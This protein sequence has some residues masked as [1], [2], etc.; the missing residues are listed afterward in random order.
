MLPSGS[1]RQ[2]YDHLCA[3]P[4]C[5][6]TTAPKLQVDAAF[7]ALAEQCA[8]GDFDSFLQALLVKLEQAEPGNSFY[9]ELGWGVAEPLAFEAVRLPPQEDARRCFLLRDARALEAMVASWARAEALIELSYEGFT[10]FDATARILYESEANRRITGYTREECL[11]KSL[12]DF[13]HPEDAE[14]LIPRFARLA[15]RPGE[16]DGDIVRWRHREGHWIY[17]E[18]TVVNQLGDPHIG[19]MINTF[20]D[21]TSRVE[22]ERVLSEAKEAAETA[23]AKQREF[24]AMLSHE[25]RTPLALVKQPLET[26]LPAEGADPQ[27]EFVKRGLRRMEALVDELVDFTILDAGQAQLRVRQVPVARILAEWVEELRP[28]AESRAMSIVLKSG[29]PGLDVFLDLA[30]FSKVVFNLLGNALKFAPAGSTVVVGYREVGGEDAGAPR[31]LEIEV[32]DAGVAIPEAAR[33]RI[34]ERFFQVDSGDT[35]GWEGMG[36]GLCLAA[37]M[38]ALHG[39]EIG[40]RPD[41]LRGNCFWVSVPLGADHIAPE[42]IALGGE[43]AAMPPPPL[44]VEA[45]SSTPAELISVAPDNGSPQTRLL[46][47]ED[48]PDLMR[49][50]ALHLESIYELEFA[51]NGLDALSLIETRRPDLIVS[52][53]M[54]PGL[55]GVSLCRQV[56]EAHSAEALPIILLSAKGSMDDRV[57][58]LEAGA[59]DY[60]GKPFVMSELINRLQLLAGRGLRAETELC[61][62]GITRLRQVIEERLAEADFSIEFLARQC[63]L[64][65][66]QLQR[67]TREELGQSPGG[68]VNQIRVAKAKTLLREAKHLTVA[69]IAAAVGLTPHYFS[70]LFRGM[71]GQTPLGFRARG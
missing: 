7:R 50:L 24:L 52:D 67:L 2:Q 4:W 38:V 20:H 68:W 54:M 58:G 61:H 1:K 62:A 33:E 8:P 27:W 21:V 47:V 65:I 35:R 64:S 11:G 66:R 56:R 5:L 39:G 40:L 12:F 41:R 13:I 51:V 30:K 32:E 25:L 18:G 63:G 44:P 45:F 16:M 23:Q 28:L 3:A 42:E 49:Y 31:M 70:R 57:K 46:I 26:L 53:V 22:M 69:E 10:V 29:D 36:L 43:E 9:F 15:E 17:L 34:F 19:G 71:T 14:R 37:E 55:D 48:H 59:N 6:I 60:L